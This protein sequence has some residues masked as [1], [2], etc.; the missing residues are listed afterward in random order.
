[1]NNV[2]IKYAFFETLFHSKSPIVQAPKA[3]ISY[4]CNYIMTLYKICSQPKQIYLKVDTMEY[5]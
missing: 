2:G 4:T 1:M 5:G 3:G